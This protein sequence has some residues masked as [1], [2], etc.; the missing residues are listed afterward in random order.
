MKTLKLALLVALQIGCGKTTAVVPTGESNGLVDC[1]FQTTETMVWPTDKIERLSDSYICKNPKSKLCVR[2]VSESKSM[3]DCGNL[4]WY[5]FPD[6]TDIP[7][8]DDY[9]P[10][11]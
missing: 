2:L 10:G 1:V 4:Q 9:L 3:V 7:G 8:E 11:T 5:F 6:G